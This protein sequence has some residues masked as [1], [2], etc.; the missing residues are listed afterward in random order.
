KIYI[1]NINL[2]VMT[3]YSGAFLRHR[4]IDACLRDTHKKYTLDDFIVACTEAS[5]SKGNKKGNYT[6]STR[7][8][9]LDLQ[10]MRDKKKGYNAPIVVF[11]HKFYKY[12]DPTFSIENVALKK[13]NLANLS[14]IVDTLKHYS[15]FNELKNLRNVINILKEEIE[16]KLEKRETVISYEGK[17]SPLGLEYFDTLHDAIINKKALCIGYY[18]SRSNNIMSIIFYPFFLKEY[19]GRWFTLGYKDGLKGVYRLPLDRIRDFSYS[20]LPF[21]AELSFNPDEYFYDIIGV[22]KLSGDVKEIKFLVKNKLAPYINVNPLHHTQQVIE[23]HE[24]GDYIFTINIIPNKEFYNL[25]SEYQPYIRIISPKEIGVQ[26][27]SKI[28]ELV[29]QLPNYNEPVKKKAEKLNEDNL[30]DTIDLFSQL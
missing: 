6:V 24:N 10:F 20:I 5:R 30:K 1:C 29:G 16:A 25:I 21:P 23:K 15:S 26:A 14:N 17:R 28:L 13:D 7:T 8:I 22:R 27:N 2:R 18:S 9:Q 12:K 4:I 11:E 19:K 3:S